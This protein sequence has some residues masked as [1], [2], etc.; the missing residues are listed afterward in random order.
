VSPVL[1]DMRAGP[2]HVRSSQYY[3]LSHH[4]WLAL[5]RSQ[6]LPSVVAIAVAVLAGCDSSVVAPPPPAVVDVVPGT[7][8]VAGAPPGRMVYPRTITAEARNAYTCETSEYSRSRDEYALRRIEIPSERRTQTEEGPIRL[9][10]YLSWD[11]E[12]GQVL[13]EATCAVPAGVEASEFVDDELRAE[14][15][16]VM[17]TDG[18]ALA[19]MAGGWGDAQIECWYDDFTG[20]V[21]CYGVTCHPMLS[22]GSGAD[23]DSVS[24]M[25]LSSYMTWDCDNG[26]TIWASGS[27]AWYNCPSA[28]GGDVCMED[29]GGGGDPPPSGPVTVTCSPAQVQRG[30][31]VPCNATGATDSIQWAFIPDGPDLDSVAWLAPAG[32]P[33]GGPMVASGTVSATG[34]SSGSAVG[35]GG[36]QFI[37]VTPRDWSNSAPAP[38]IRYEGQGD[39]PVLPEDYEDLGYTLPALE[40]AAPG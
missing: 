26:C 30:E 33:W 24:D 7:A 39:L 32:S 35:G 3:P 19:A 6:S 18:S 34:Y 15:Q 27:G 4:G 25:L 12:S 5:R 28:G 17:A 14:A 10:R 23:P 1:L 38:Q 16:A 22:L 29:C 11:R 2:D 36:A 13:F 20:Q 21:E 37:T 8:V 40:V 31:S 9:L